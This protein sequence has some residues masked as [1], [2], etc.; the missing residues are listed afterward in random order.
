L[1]AESAS[2]TGDFARA[3]AE[4]RLAIE[5]L[6]DN[7][8]DVATVRE[9]LGEILAHEGNY[10]ESLVEY[11]AAYYEE[12]NRQGEN[13]AAGRSAVSIADILAEM[14]RFDEVE[15]EAQRGLAAATI[16]DDAYG[17]VHCHVN[18]LRV[19]LSRK[20]V[21]GRNDHLAPITRAFA[22]LAPDE[23]QT[24]AEAL[25][26]TFENSRT[27]RPRFL[28]RRG[29]LVARTRKSCGFAR[30]DRCACAAHG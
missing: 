11:R 27:A 14:G 16:S 23:K 19:A 18:L 29:A 22:K 1:L 7:R 20:D 6:A 13:R 3:E 10:E 17:V 28:G 25:A 5:A 21:A 30:F 8:R 2:L 26:T 4:A 12:E 15:I 24:I 9:S